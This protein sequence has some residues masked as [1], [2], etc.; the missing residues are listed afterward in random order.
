MSVTAS[1]F[2]SLSLSYMRAMIGDCET[3]RAMVAQPDT[4][5]DTLK[6]LIDAATSSQTDALNKIQYGRLEDRPNNDNLLNRPRC[7]VRHYEFGIDRNSTTGFGF[8]GMISAFFEWPIPQCYRDNRSEATMD[9]ENKLGNLIQEL[10][11]LPTQAG[12][13]HINSGDILVGQA[14]PVENKGE[15]FWVSELS[16]KHLGSILP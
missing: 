10:A 15:Q 8:K 6:T 14:D 4:D 13:L 5:W 9:A 3:W 12:Y 16:I 7:G 1:G 2:L 11:A